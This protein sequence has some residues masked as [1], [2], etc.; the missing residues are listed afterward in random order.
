MAITVRNV[1]ETLF[2]EFK[3]EAVKEGIP[4]G[5]ALNMAMIQWISK[6]KHPKKSLLNYKP[7]NWGKGTEDTSKEI[8]NVLYG[9]K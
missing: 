9:K 6:H 5:K 7:T 1:D 4:I 8:N 3:V 2:Q